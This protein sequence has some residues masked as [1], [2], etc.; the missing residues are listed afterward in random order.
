MSFSSALAFEF[1]CVPPVS[2][3]FSVLSFYLYL[4]QRDAV[5]RETMF[6]GK[7][8][9]RWKLVILLLRWYRFIPADVFSEARGHVRFLAFFQFLNHFIQGKVDDV[10]VMK[11]FRGY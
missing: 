2:S 1:L 6:D 4:V 11:L 9:A 10:V 7:R 3:V 5:R 8:N